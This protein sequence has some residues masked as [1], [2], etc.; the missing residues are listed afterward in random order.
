MCRKNNMW[1]ISFKTSR[2]DLKNFSRHRRARAKPETTS[3]SLKDVYTMKTQ[4][5]QG[6]NTKNQKNNIYIFSNTSVGSNKPCDDTVASLR[7]TALG[8]LIITSLNSLN[9]S[10]LVRRKS[11]HYATSTQVRLQ[12][13]RSYVNTKHPK[14]YH[15]KIMC[16]SSYQTMYIYIYINITISWHHHHQNHIHRQ[17][18]QYT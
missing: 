8:E 6:F 15:C 16:K 1:I 9:R 11:P 7:Y 3:V 4:Y 17:L 12:G 14:V 5:I 10:L 2:A 13:A 18:K